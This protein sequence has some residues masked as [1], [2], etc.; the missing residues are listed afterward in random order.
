MRIM[1]YCQHVLGIGHLVRTFEIL[2]ALHHHEITLV[3]GGSQTDI[4]IPDHVTTVQLPPLMMDTSFQ[5]LSSS[6]QSSLIEV[7]HSR[8]QLLLKTLSTFRPE[9]L[10]VEL[11]PFGRNAFHFELEPL[12]QKVKE[13]F[14]A[15]LVASSVR[16]ILVE[17]D[18][19]IK[20]E[21]RAIERLNSH[22]D[23]LLIHSDPDIIKLDKTFSRINDIAIPVKYT[24]YI[25]RPPNSS[26]PKNT[27]NNNAF[28]LIIA[29]AGGGSVGFKLLKATLKGFKEFSKTH[30]AALKMFTGPY[31]PEN[32]KDEL[33]RLTTDDV[34]IYTFSKSLPDELQDANLSVSMGGYN[35]TMDILSSGC[36]ALIYP[37][38]QNHE[39]KLRAKHLQKHAPI[40]LLEDKDLSPIQ[41]AKHLTIGLGCQKKAMTVK[42]D[43]AG[44]SAEM[45][46]TEAHKKQ[47]HYGK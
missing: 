15:C 45:L 34:T 31:L 12:L 37:F 17:R 18:N 22:F 46:I 11:Y 5:N 24:N 6:S 35:T 7:K 40:I 32:K 26:T 19:K 2:K 23:L 42:L 16:D 1:V 21:Q 9:I 41:M 28:S 36:P 4:P 43:G 20:F 44:K 10:L 25:H 29:S 27:N 3:L 47:K 13:D 30:K 14:P 33:L 39:Q 38:K 8:Q